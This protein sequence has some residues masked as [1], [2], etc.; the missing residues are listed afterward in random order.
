[1]QIGG[2]NTFFPFRPVAFKLYRLCGKR[3]KGYCYANP[4]E[5]KTPFSQWIGRRI[6]KYEFI[7]NV[8]FTIVEGF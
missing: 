6:N 2:G 3:K 1:M 8:D 5:Q 4:L 7:E